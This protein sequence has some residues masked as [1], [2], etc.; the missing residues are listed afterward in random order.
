MAAMSRAPGA[1]AV[2]EHERR[3]IEPV[4]RH[5]G[6]NGEERRL[7]S[8]AASEQAMRVDA[9]GPKR[10]RVPTT[11]ASR[12]HPP[13][14]ERRDVSSTRWARSPRRRAPPRRPRA[15]RGPPRSPRRSPGPAPL[16]G[17]LSDGVATSHAAGLDDSCVHT[18]Q[19]Q[20]SA[21]WR[22][23]EAGRVRAEAR[24]EL[25]A[26]R[27]RHVGHL[28]DRRAECEPRSRRKVLRPQV[29]VDVELVPRE[30]PPFPVG[31][32]QRDHA[33]VHERELRARVRGL[34]VLPSARPPAVSDQ[35]VV[36]IELA[37]L[38][39]LSLAL[40]RPANDQVD[41]S[42]GAGARSMSGRPASSSAAGTCTSLVICPVR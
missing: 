1:I 27:V 22:V 33:R 30:S 38:E 23:H 28:D 9:I 42:L 25:R 7:L 17:E 11:S 18:A 13:E 35:A 41:G 5:P 3:S 24:R 16:E 8:M 29:E 26:P 4:A 20:R 34:A 15:R 19:A 32:Q 36:E 37:F 6:E 12:L 39:N 2:E 31:R 14:P 10:N 21:S 40:R